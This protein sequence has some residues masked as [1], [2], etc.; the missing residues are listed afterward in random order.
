MPTAFISYVEADYPI[1]TGVDLKVAYDFYDPDIDHKTGAASRYS[2][3]V[4]FF[5]LPGVE[6]RPIYRAVDGDVIGIKNEFD[7]LLHLYF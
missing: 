4:E 3:G 6:L 5:P 1:V 2:F 7:M